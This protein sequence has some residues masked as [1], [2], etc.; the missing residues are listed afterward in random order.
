MTSARRGAGIDRHAGSAAFAAATARS[1]S[2]G[3]DFGKVPIRSSRS[4]GFRF[5]NRSPVEASTHEPLTKFLYVSGEAMAVL[6]RRLPPGSWTEV[7]DR[8][9]WIEC[10]V[11]RAYDALS[12][13]VKKPCADGARP[14]RLTL[15]SLEC[16]K[17]GEM[18]NPLRL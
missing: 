13:S 8:G 14:S 10:D 16:E 17:R 11:D 12:E 7:R 6:L 3:P 9:R 15:V 1:T 5:S 18:K 2:S 4:A